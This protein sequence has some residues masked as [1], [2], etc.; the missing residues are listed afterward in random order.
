MKDNKE[1]KHSQKE[2]GHEELSLENSSTPVSEV[3]DKMRKIK[4]SEYRK[5]LSEFE[6]YK[7]KYYRVH[8]EFENVRKRMERDKLEFLKYANEGLI[9][10]FLTILDNLERSVEAARTKHEDYDAF[11]KGIEM[12]MAH[13]HE[14]LKKNGVKPIQAKGQIFDPHSHEVLLQEETDEGEDGV[15][16]EEL[17]KGYYFQDRVIRTAKVKVAKKKS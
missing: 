5:I 8:A 9:A 13:I 10:E 14:M 12:I 7:D 3:E 6:E 15:V 11:L 4:E 2:K 1:V 16:V 17:Q